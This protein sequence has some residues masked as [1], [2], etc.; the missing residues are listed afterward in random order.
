MAALC[1]VVTPSYNDAPF[2]TDC[3]TSVYDAA[4]RATVDVEHVIADD[5]STDD[6]PAVLDRLSE[7]YGVRSARLSENRGCSAALNAAISMTDA[8]W[9]LVLASD[10]MVKENCFSEWQNAVTAHPGANVVYSDLELFGRETGLYKTPAFRKTLLRE[11]NILPGCSFLRRQLFDAVGGFAVS[12]RTAQDWDFWVRADMAV[13]L[14]PKKVTTP[15]VRYRRHH[16]PR[17]H[18]ETVANFTAIQAHIQ[19]LARGAA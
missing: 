4:R 16:T 3:V 10:D 11:R 2:L 12:L 18:N 7:A 17:L 6:T 14:R 1:A 13:G 15:M 9:L 5:A 19:R 8:P